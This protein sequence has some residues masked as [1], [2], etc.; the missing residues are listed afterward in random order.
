MIHI[1]SYVDLNMDRT[2]YIFWYVEL[3]ELS[4]HVFL[5]V[6]GAIY[7]PYAPYIVWNMDNNIG[8]IRSTYYLSMM[9]NIW[10]PGSRVGVRGAETHGKQFTSAAAVRGIKEVTD[11]MI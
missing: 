8:T 7:G 3:Y 2:V 11:G 9:G 6:N 10:T 1:F 4:V 5:H